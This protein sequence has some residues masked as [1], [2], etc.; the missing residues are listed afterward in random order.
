VV[1]DQVIAGR[2]RVRSLLGA[3][4]MGAV[5]LAYD[6]VL[7]RDVALKRVQ[8]NECDENQN[9][10]REARAAAGIVHSGVV[11]VHDVLFGEDG[12]WIVMEALPGRTLST[13][14][15]D[16]GRLPA[17]EV[18][19]IGLHLLS[20]LQAIHDAGLV[21]RD[22]KPSN[23]QI[24]DPDRVV[25]TDFGLSSPHGVWGGLQAGAIA[26]SLPF[27]AP[28]SIIDGRFGPSSDLF[29]LGVTLYRAV[30]GRAPFD[31]REPLTV[32]AVRSRSPRPAVHAG[33]LGPVLD[34]LLENDPARRLDVVRARSQLRAIEPAATLAWAG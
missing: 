18:V 16:R 32:E 25:L 28:E 5:W 23:V 1:T 10:L 22:V 24:C 19:P 31:P 12:E 2:Y 29:A 15:G 11:R 6:E 33:C 17:D 14:I 30:E 26:G 21:H 9:A 7:R 13:I 3:G 27:L 20:A 8:N 4:G 34:G